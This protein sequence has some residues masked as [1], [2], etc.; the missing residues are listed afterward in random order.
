MTTIIMVNHKL[1]C[2]K[3]TLW[4]TILLTKAFESSFYLFCVRYLL[5]VCCRFQLRIAK[6]NAFNIPLNAQHTIMGFLWSWNI[7]PSIV[8]RMKAWNMKLLILIYAFI[9]GASISWLHLAFFASKKAQILVK[10]I[11]NFI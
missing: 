1:K 11:I 10:K 8:D 6:F 2:H 7:C 5:A 3:G 9:A 4:F